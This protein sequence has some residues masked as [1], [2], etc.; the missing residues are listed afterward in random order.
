[1]L[2]NKKINKIT[3]KCLFPISVCVGIVSISLLCEASGTSSGSVGVI[4]K[5]IKNITDLIK[6]DGK[7]GLQILSAAAGGIGS[8]KTL[9]WQPLVIGAGGAGVLEMIFQAIG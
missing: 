3:K 4:Q 5:V 6:T 9:S 8:A 2:K 1:M 7:I